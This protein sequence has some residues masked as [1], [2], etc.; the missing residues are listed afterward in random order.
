MVLQAGGIASFNIQHGYV[1]A[2]VRGFR[3]GFL[4]DVDYH[5]LTQCESLEGAFAH[6]RDATCLLTA[7]GSLDRFSVIELLVLTC[8]VCAWRMLCVDVKLNLQE[9]DYDQ[10]LA[11]EV[12]SRDV[13]ERS[14]DDDVA[15]AV[16]DA[17]LCATLHS[18]RR[19]RR[20]SSRQGPR[21]SLSPSFTS[22]APRRS[23][24]SCSSWITSRTCERMILHVY[25]VTHVPMQM[26]LQSS[27][28]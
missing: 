7:V 21:T 9:T 16:S 15:F 13:D 3:S 20:R 14:Q 24:R 23:S 1:E 19:S 27:R 10:F 11:D 28:Y 17:S 2:L 6:T 22:C 25:C 4:D 12:R 5:H 18:L 26:L 8:L